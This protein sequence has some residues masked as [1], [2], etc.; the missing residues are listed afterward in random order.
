VF[1][2]PFIKAYAA[3]K[4]LEDREFFDVISPWERRFLLLH[5]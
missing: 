1:G 4:E 3:I 2:E 5:V